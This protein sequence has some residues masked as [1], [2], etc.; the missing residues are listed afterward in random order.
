[1]QSTIASSRNF[2][3]KH[4]ERDTKYGKKKAWNANQ[5]KETKSASYKYSNVSAPQPIVHSPSWNQSCHP[6]NL[7]DDVHKGFVEARMS[8]GPISQDMYESPGHSDATRSS[9]PTSI[10]LS[11]KKIMK[12]SEKEKVV[13]LV[14]IRM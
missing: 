9:P 12:T 8:H 13:L 6:S 4:H 7:Q 10:R 11:I 3:R 14:Y 5:N 1:M 2:E